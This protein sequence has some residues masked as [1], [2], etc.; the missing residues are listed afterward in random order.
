MIL[1]LWLL[2]FCNSPFN[3]FRPCLVEVNELQKAWAAGWW[4]WWWWM[5]LISALRRPRQMDFCECSRRMWSTRGSSRPTRVTER[6]PV[7]KEKW[8]NAKIWGLHTFCA[9]KSHPGP[10]SL[11]MG[12]PV[13][14]LLHSDF[15]NRRQG[16]RRHCPWLRAP[17][18]TFQTAEL[19]SQQRGCHSDTGRKRCFCKSCLHIWVLG[20]FGWGNHFPY[21][22]QVQLPWYNLVLPPSLLCM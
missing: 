14:A 16:M 21:R 8:M 18:L 15:I 4:W 22:G 9:F 1:S 11:A 3:S 2:H 7:S 6:N 10:Y 13:P 20:F 5:T 17:L 12:Q 19:A